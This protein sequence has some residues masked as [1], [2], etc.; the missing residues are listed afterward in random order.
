VEFGEGDPERLEGPG[1]CDVDAASPIHKDL[2]DPVVS[3]H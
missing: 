2:L 1:E 3:N